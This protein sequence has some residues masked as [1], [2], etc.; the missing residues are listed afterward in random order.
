MNSTPYETLTTILVSIF[1]V[2]KIKNGFP[3]G[4][5]PLA[6]YGTESHK[7]L[8]RKIDAGKSHKCEGDK[9]RGDKGDAHSL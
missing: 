1:L 8:P 4:Y 7:T 5:Y 6:G 3:K 9:S 2:K